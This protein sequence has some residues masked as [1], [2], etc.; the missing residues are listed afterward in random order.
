MRP[1]ML[2]AL[3][4]A[5]LL[6]IVVAAPVAW[7]VSGRS[8]Q[9]DPPVVVGFD[10]NP[11]GNSCPGTGNGGGTDCTLGPIDSCVS[12]SAG[13]SVEFDVFVDGIPG[14]EDLAGPDYYIG[15][16]WWPAGSFTLASR[17]LQ[18][19]GTNLLVDD[20]GSSTLIDASGP[21]PPHSSSPD[22]SAIADLGTAETNPPYTKG[23]LG[24]YTASVAPGTPPGIYGMVFD[25]SDTGA[26]VYVYNQDSVDMCTTY[27][28]DL[29]DAAHSPQ[30][31]LIAV[32]T[33]CAAATPVP[34]P[35]ASPT[36]SPV[37]SGTPTPGPSPTPT[38]TPGPGGLVAGWNHVCYLGPD[39]PIEDA[40]VAF[41]ESVVAVY[42][43]ESAGGYAR[44]FPGRPDLSNISTVTPF[45]PLFI[46][47]ASSAPWQQQPDGTPP[48]SIQLA[49]GWNSVCYSG[50]TK[51]TEEATAGIAGQVG[52]LYWLAPE[53]AWRRFVPGRPEISD[54]PELQQ[55]AAT[56]VLATQPEGVEW[57]F[58]P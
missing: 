21:P 26:P 54:L 39:Q 53:Q 34:S 51:G 25:Q 35:T 46:L 10:M 19:A 43:L 50:Q 7:H 6:S 9:A 57:V 24:R 28:C 11:T 15:W 31:G 22:H 3:V 37:P 16:D 5:A 52:V 38:A 12:V 45:Q 48:T 56:L 27:G 14:G 8:A 17:T 44:W 23:V 1:I 18:A 32:D 58:D 33:A 2:G 13:S 55:F 36:P 49:Q 40:L 29:W 42:R 4:G 20:A 41:G 47:M 30:Y